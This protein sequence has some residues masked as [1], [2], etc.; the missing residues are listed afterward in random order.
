MRITPALTLVAVMFTSGC[1]TLSGL[2]QVIQPPR[3]EQAEGQ[4]AELR[5]LTPSRSSPVG[6]AGVASG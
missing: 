4:P 5:I 3:F 1:A 6:G 2:S